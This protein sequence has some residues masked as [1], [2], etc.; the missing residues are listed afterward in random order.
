MLKLR[1]YQIDLSTKGA[2]ILKDLNIVIFSAE[3]RTGKTFIALE[4]CN[5]VNAKKVLFVT[6]KKAISSIQNDYNK[7]NTTYEIQIINYESLHKITDKDFDV[8]ICDEIHSISAYPKPS[9]RTKL[10]KNIVQNKKLIGLSGTLTP[11]SFS[12]IYHIFWISNHTPFIEKSFY[13]W[14]KVFVNITTKLINGYNVN[15]YS[16]GNQ[17]LIEQYTDKYILSFTQKEAGFTSKVEEQ[18]LNVKMSKTIYLIAD[19]LKKDKVFEGKKG[20]V[21]LA[22]TGGKLMQKLH[23][24]YSGTVI[25]EDGTSIILDNTKANFIHSRFRNKKIAIFYKFKAELEALQE[26]YKDNLTTD[27]NEFNTTDKSIALQFQS[28]KEGIS[29]ALADVLVAYNIDFSS[30]TYWQFRDRLTTK[31]RLVN[32]L[33]WIF[34]ENGIEKQIHRTVMKKKNFTLKYYE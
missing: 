2:D 24:I 29:L 7:L 6:K 27:L 20:G 18:V 23:Q 22:D 19:K 33:Y 21:I 3:V 28:G 17:K 10:L 11:E 30:S 32:K 25:L 13:K 4:T 1:D 26:I 14:A 15:D 9:K 16:Q 5:K 12:Q 34:S 8:I 31:E